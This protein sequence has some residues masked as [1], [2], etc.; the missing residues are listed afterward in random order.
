[1]T[2][3]VIKETELREI[4]ERL[5]AGGATMRPATDLEMI[6]RVLERTGNVDLAVDAILMVPRPRWVWDLIAYDLAGTQC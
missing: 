3:V 6:A 2:W 5:A 4:R 1:M